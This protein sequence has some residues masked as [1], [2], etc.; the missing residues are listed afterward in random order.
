VE[1]AL[2]R[3]GDLLNDASTDR[4]NQVRIIH[5]KGTGALRR[6]IREYLSGHPLVASVAP[7]EGPSGDGATVVELK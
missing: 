6:A 1:E 7:D 5:G 3:V 4:L 2:D